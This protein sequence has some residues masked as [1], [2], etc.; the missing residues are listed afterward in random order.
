M[1]LLG[2]R[3]VERIV[4]RKHSWIYSAMAAGR[5]PK[6]VPLDQRGR[7]VAWL[8]SEIDAFIAGL[9]ALRDEA[10]ADPNHPINKERDALR[11]ARVR[12]LHPG[13]QAPPP[14]PP[15]KRGRPRLPPDERTQ[16]ASKAKAAAAANL[17]QRPRGRSRRAVPEHAEA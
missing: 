3:D 7:S 13:W 9:R 15:K 14:T 5:F 8:S 17:K 10:E 4:G 6:P 2:L 16:R 1:R 12:S 11:D